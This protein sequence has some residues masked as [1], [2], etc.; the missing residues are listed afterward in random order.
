MIVVRVKVGIVG[1]MFVLRLQKISVFW[2]FWLLFNYSIL[3]LYIFVYIRIFFVIFNLL[4][5]SDIWLLI[6]YSSIG[7]TGIILLRVFGSNYL[8]V[9]FLYL[10]IILL[11]IVLMKNI[12]SLTELLL[13]VFFFLVIPPFMLFLIKFYVVYSLDIGLKLRFL[14]VFFDVFVLLYYFSL[15]FIKFILFD[16]GILIYIINLLLLLLLLFLRNCVT[17]IFFY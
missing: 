15:I 12:N 7:N 16:S 5:V 4:L 2:M 11:I 3:L 13:L 9:V 8:F 17:M 6:V 1:N 14:V 10:L